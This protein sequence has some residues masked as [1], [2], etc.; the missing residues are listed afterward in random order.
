MKNRREKKVEERKT[1]SNTISM[2]FIV[3]YD[4][5]YD[6]DVSKITHRTQLTTRILAPRYT[7]L[8]VR[9]EDNKVCRLV[10]IGY[11]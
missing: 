4:Y 6:Y 1:K 10:R 7:C 9:I 8:R 11:N 2:I 5:D 3:Q